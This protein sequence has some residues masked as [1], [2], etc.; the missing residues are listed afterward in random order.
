MVQ[1]D[2]SSMGPAFGGFLRHSQHGE[3]RRQQKMQPTVLIEGYQCLD[4][5]AMVICCR[6]R[7]Y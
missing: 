2:I 6:L 1:L 3:L 4:A 5:W 7:V